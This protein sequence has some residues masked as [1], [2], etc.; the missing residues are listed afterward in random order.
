MKALKDVGIWWVNTLSEAKDGPREPIK[1]VPMRLRE[2]K[3]VVG[4]SW[5]ES[6]QDLRSV[7]EQVDAGEKLSPNEEV[8]VECLPFL[9][10][11]VNDLIVYSKQPTKKSMMVVL[12]TGE[13]EYA[14]RGLIGEDFRSYKPCICL[15]GLGYPTVPGL[16]MR[17]RGFGKVEKGRKAVIDMV[18][19]DYLALMEK[20]KNAADEEE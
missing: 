17:G 9:D 20:M 8:A 12:V 5:T 10:I 11:P 6:S 7:R 4:W 3:A 15:D 16:P 1:Y 19:D 14:D 2:G 13:Y 18:K